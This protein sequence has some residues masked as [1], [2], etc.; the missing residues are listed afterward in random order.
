MANR[1][2]ILRRKTGLFIKTQ[3]SSDIGRVFEVSLYT[4][5]PSVFY[6][7]LVRGHEKIML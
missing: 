6:I 2:D 4:G 1:G 7:L 5:D 3:M